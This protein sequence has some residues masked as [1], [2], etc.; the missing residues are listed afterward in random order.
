MKLRFDANQDFQLEAIA[1]VVD[2][3]DGQ[4]R[5]EAPE[6]QLWEQTDVAA[7]T[8]RLT[9]SDEQIVGNLRAVQTANRI[10]PDPGLRCIEGTATL[11][12]EDRPVRFANF[13]VE[14][15][16]GTGKT[17]VYLRTILELNRR[18]GLRK[19]VVVV[20]SVA[21]REGVLKTLDITEG[22]FRAIYDNAPYAYY[23]Y[24]SANLARVRQFAQSNGVEI[25]IM[26]IDSFNKA[27]N[28]M[29][30]SM[31]QMQGQTPIHLV[32]A[33]R[34]V[35]ILD[36]PQNLESDRSRSALASLNPL[37]ALRY[38][39]THRDPYNLVYRLTPYHAY[40]RGLVKRIQVASVVKTDDANRPFIRLEEIKVRAG[41]AVA[42]LA[43]HKLMARGAVREQVVTVAPGDR[44]TEKAGRSEYEGYDVDTIDPVAGFVRFAPSDVELRAGEAVGADK[45]AIFRAQI[46]YTIERHVEAQRRLRDRGV[47]VLSLFFIDRV[48][49]YAGED[50]LIRRLFDQA[51]EGL[52]AGLPEWK[53]LS[54]ADVQAAY[55]AE[56]R[57]RS[58][59]VELLESAT[60]ESQQDEAA[61]DLIMRDKEALLSFP[62]PNDDEETQRRKQRCF[63]FS[64]SALREGWDSP[65]VFQICTLNQA[66]SN[67][68]KR[69][70]VGR[71]VR[72]AVDQAG[73]RVL[74]NQVNILTVVANESYERYVATLQSEIADEYK[75][76]IEARYGKPIDA[77]SEEE[78]LKVAEEYGQDILPPPPAPA[79]RPRATLRKAR[80][81]SAEFREL[82]ERIKHRTRYAVTI[83]SDRLLADVMPE[84][85]RR[86]IEP[87][88]VTITE[89]EA[90]VRE[91]GGGFIAVQRRAARTAEVLD[92]KPARPNLVAVMAELM[93]HT[94]P[95]VSLTR[96]TLL[97]VVR[98]VTRKDAVLQNPY[99]FA[100]VAVGILKQKL[101]DQ[102]VDGIRYEK[103]EGG[104]WEMQR[105]LDE[106]VVALFSKYTEPAERALYD[107]VPCD[108]KVEQRFVRAMEGRSDVRLYMKLP[109]WFRVPTPLGDYQPD[110]AVV[111]ENP[112]GGEPLLYLVAETKGTV[113]EAGRRSTENMKIECARAHFGSKERN[114]M[115]ALAGVDYKVVTD[116]GQLP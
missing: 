49:N 116:A 98:R 11:G 74:D 68:R 45:E 101:V 58:G 5:V 105:I 84:L 10:S 53:D 112:D 40:Q 44:L 111:L 81:E 94:T 42:R 3:F 63:I 79:D 51:F 48:S 76:E 33:A 22:H 110:W 57:R 20:P 26:T 70:E 29:V 36:E 28:I 103:I 21:V 32:Q 96:R 61:Y 78:R 6:F 24:D 41:R 66:A 91:G 99:E 18:C 46:R 72:L 34:P 113:D 93:E 2:L 83:D 89:A 15:E 115:G 39:A 52:K 107:A 31:D 85:N 13:S 16:T 75:A 73:E 30:R 90:M 102:L 4:P 35:L 27:A 43:V 8:N 65:N 100:R 80:V 56:Q 54:P 88:R 82:W 108:S 17:Y 92:A 77:L 23:R 71:G 106:D 60:G 55:F 97:E 25:M 50:G 87:P 47:K 95:R 69:Q 104:W 9:L 114:V 59:V 62:E 38:S 64:H 14:M 1:A 67:M 37:F 109:P 19:F 7:V 86:S 12:G